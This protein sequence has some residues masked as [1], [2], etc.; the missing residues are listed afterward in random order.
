MKK[1]IITA[2][3]FVLI[4]SHISY[5]QETTS[6]DWQKHHQLIDKQF[7]EYKD[8]VIETEKN[9]IEKLISKDKAAKYMEYFEKGL[10]CQ[11]GIIILEG[12]NNSW[13]ETAYYSGYKQKVLFH[14][15]YFKGLTKSAQAEEIY[16]PVLTTQSQNIKNDIIKSWGRQK[17]FFVKE[18]FK[19][20]EWEHAK[21]VLKKRKIKG[22]KQY[23]TGW[24][25]IYTKSQEKYLTKQPQIDALWEFEKEN[26]LKLE[27]FATE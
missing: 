17:D 26:N 7:E 10:N 11:T 8:Q 5:G 25:T 6:Y 3:I 27:G 1:I 21:Q 4:S 24:L 22:G 20:I 19:I 12:E 2:L 13:L 14:Q 18:N 23:H 15:G 9:K 16:K